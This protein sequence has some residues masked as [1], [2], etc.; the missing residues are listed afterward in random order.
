MD[1][2]QDLG[3]EMLQVVNSFI[4]TVYLLC[5]LPVLMVTVTA[6]V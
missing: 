2:I 5:H 6:T 1:P 3:H 4:L